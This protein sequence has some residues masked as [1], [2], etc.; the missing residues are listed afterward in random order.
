[1]RFLSC[2]AGIGGLDLGLER[3]GY[4]CV[5]QIEVDPYCRGVLERHWP[6]VW[7]RGDIRL[8]DPADCPAADLV[9]GG[10]PCQDTSA[11]GK[12]RGLTGW[13]S[14]LWTELLRL[15][16]GLRPRWVLV[17]N[18]PAL[19]TRG[20][21]VVLG[22]LEAAG[23]AC[24]AGVVGAWAVGAPHR[25]DR[26]WIVGHS[27]GARCG[28]NGRES[29]S[30]ERFSPRGSATPGPRVA[31]PRCVG[32]SGARAPDD[33]ARA[34]RA[35]EGDAPEREWVRHAARHGG[36]TRWVGRPDELQFPW[37]PPRTVKP[38][39]GHRVDGISTRMAL[40]ALGNAVVPQVAEAIGRA[41]LA[42]EQAT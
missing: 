34:P 28:G 15:V 10:F 29:G 3:A 18:V 25:R 22:G 16:L 5:G 32:L 31:D 12:G 41:I 42:V 19:R 27:T 14:G 7:R 23:Y 30:D 11:A 2:F 24:W 26:V 21:D 37:E 4:V 6:G 36:A 38:R 33:M 39:V 13:R 35:P 17:E 1:M 20:A 40:K 8:V 9:C